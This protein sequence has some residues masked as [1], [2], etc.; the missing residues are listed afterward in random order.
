M[1]VYSI[2]D[3]NRSKLVLHQ[4]PQAALPE[5]KELLLHTS[6]VADDLQY[7]H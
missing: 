1:Y 7:V 6:Q 4:H 5:Q 2:H 3:I